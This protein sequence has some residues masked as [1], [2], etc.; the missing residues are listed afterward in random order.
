MVILDLKPDGGVEFMARPCAGCAVTFLAGTDIGVPAWLRL[1]HTGT[2]FSATVLSADQSRSVDLG[3]I[4]VPMSVILPA[5]VVTSHD[6]SHTA[7][8]IFSNARP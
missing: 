5:L 1:T 7:V 4:T 8:G 3:S 2:T 6:P